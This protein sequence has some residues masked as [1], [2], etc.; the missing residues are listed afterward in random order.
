MANKKEAVK[1][2]ISKEIEQKDDISKQ[3]SISLDGKTNKGIFNKIFRVKYFASN[4]KVNIAYSAILYIIAILLFLF[5]TLALI[6]VYSWDTNVNSFVKTY[7]SKFL[8][9]IFGSADEY[10]KWQNNYGF[11][12]ISS[13][14]SNPIVGG[15]VSLSVI[16]GK[17]IIISATTAMSFIGLFVL[18]VSIIFKKQTMAS[19]ISLGLSTVFLIICLSLFAILISGN[20]LNDYKTFVQ[21]C[22]GKGGLKEAMDAALKEFKDTE[23]ITNSKAAI[24]TAFTNIGNFFKGLKG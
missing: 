2:D 11:D 15:G 14:L 22:N 9:A 17:E 10:A 7:D 6:M 3:T 12:F 18:I 1:K 16:L 19:Y 8:N 5:A 21:L 24:E 23:A 20:F 4:K 13:T